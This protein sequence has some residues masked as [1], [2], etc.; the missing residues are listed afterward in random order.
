MFWFNDLFSFGDAGVD[1][2][3]VLSGFIIYY[4]TASNHGK[5]H[6][7]GNYLKHRLARIYPIYW[8]VAL[9][10]LPMG[11]IFGHWPGNINVIK[12]FMLRPHGDMPFIPVAWT[13]IHEMFFY[14]SFLLFFINI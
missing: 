13:L 2:F 14:V 10:L 3:F 5:L 8:F 1:F 11:V 12:D 4:S 7:A 6:L 9:L